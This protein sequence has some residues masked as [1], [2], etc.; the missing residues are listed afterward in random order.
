MEKSEYKVIV[1]GHI[2]LDVTPKFLSPQGTPMDKLFV[3]GKLINMGEVNISSG[4]PVSN[5]GIALQKMGVNAKLMGKIG[6]DLF[7]NAL[8]SLLKEQNNHEGM[9]M[10]NGEQTSYTIVIVPPGVDRI[11]LHN[12]GANNTFVAD[13][14]DYDYI[15][16][17]DL[18]HFGYPPLMQNMFKN[19]GRQL[20]ETFQKV[21]G[22][23]VTTSLDMSIPDRNS[24]SGKTDWENV[25]KKTLPNVDLFLPSYEEIIYMI[26]R[27]KFDQMGG[28]SNPHDLLENFDPGLLSHLSDKLLD[29]GAKIV[30]IKCGEKGFYIRTANKETLENIG[31]VKPANLDNW[32]NREIHEES[33]KVEEIASATGS[34]DSSIAGFLSSYLNGLTIEQAVKMACAV[35]AQNI[36]RFDALSGIKDWKYTEDFVAKNPE[37]N[38]LD[39][40]PSGWNYKKELQQWE[41][42]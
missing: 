41:K 6:D 7:G 16:N 23:G 38:S 19:E 25:L 31:R 5:T 40:T 11:F 30:V 13:D 20:A 29:F 35:G 24:E 34:G 14:L 12:P 9:I 8:Y 10:M 1:A 18:F 22:L 32:A 27:D 15:K 4:G 2:C 42:K 21:K 36:T 33:Y 28:K 39:L 26:A 3:P 37:K 17:A